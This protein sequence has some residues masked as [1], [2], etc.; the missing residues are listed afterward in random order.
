MN[1]TA[2]IC[3]KPMQGAHQSHVINGAHLMSSQAVLLSLIGLRSNCA[4][5]LEVFVLLI[6]CLLYNTALTYL[7]LIIL[8]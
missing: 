1:Y 7:K 8:E 5:I 4:F 3:V 6:K 2:R